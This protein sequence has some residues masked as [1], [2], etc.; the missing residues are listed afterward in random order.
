MF[1]V[2]FRHSLFY[3]TFCIILRQC[4]IIVKLGI[5]VTKVK[6][7]VCCSLLVGLLCSFGVLQGCSQEPEPLEPMDFETLEVVDN[8]MEAMRSQ[9]DC[10][11]RYFYLVCNNDFEQANKFIDRTDLSICTPEILHELYSNVQNYVF[12]DAVRV[13]DAQ[14]YDGYVTLTFIN[15]NDTERSWDVSYEEGEVP[16][17]YGSTMP[18]V[19][20][21]DYAST[22]EL[23]DVNEDGVIDET[24]MLWEDNP[25]LNPN[26][27]PEYDIEDV[28]STSTSTRGMTYVKISD[29]AL[30]KDITAVA[31]DFIDVTSTLDEVSGTSIATSD[32]VDADILSDLYE[33]QSIVGY[34]TYSIDIRINEVDGQYKVQLPDTMVSSTKLMI[35]VPDGVRIKVGDLELSKDIMNLDDFYVVTK[36]PKVERFDVELENLITGSSTKTIDL[37][38]RVYYIYSSILPTRGMKDEVLD[39]GKEA[40][41]ALYDDMLR[42][43]SFT[44]SNFVKKYV[45]SGGNVAS[46]RTNYETYLTNRS[47]GIKTSFEVLAVHFPTDKDELYDTTI[48]S[49]DFRVTSYECV[50][51]PLVLDIR[52]NTVV[53]GETQIQRIMVGGKL[54][55]TKVDNEWFVYDISSELMLYGI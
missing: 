27:V 15:L 21:I 34:K 54:Y 28:T 39:Y 40:L 41:Q 49:D 17:W 31:D 14:I 50:T 36:L 1:K 11:V 45:A 3:C 47:L 13:V 52:Q 46:I 4:V 42:G 30:A 53:D 35:R 7:F 6:K 48:T 16:S 19:Y 44:S 18:Y 8:N 9:R 32:I 51:V 37:T 12:D 43:V 20:D 24:D 2:I 5:G 22:Y 38:Q 10:A 33:K 26:Y 29:E 25:E 55:L 23:E